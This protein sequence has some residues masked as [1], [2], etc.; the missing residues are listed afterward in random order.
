MSSVVFSEALADRTRRVLASQRG[1]TEKKMFGGLAFLL[2]GNLCV[3]IWKNQ[4]IARLG[5]RAAESALGAPNVR[6]FDITGRPMKGWVMIE[7]EGL[8]T[9]QQLADWVEASIHF[10]RT[11]PRKTR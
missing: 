1:I 8:E 2:G 9:D 11:L 6:E 5:H 4:L 7:P 3:G 10:V